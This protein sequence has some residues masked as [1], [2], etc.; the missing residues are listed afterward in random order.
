MPLRVYNSL[1]RRV[2][3]FVPADPPRV[4]LYACGPTVYDAVHVGNCSFYLAVDVL[5]RW[6]RHRGYE[7]TYVQNVTDVED[8]I[9]RD[10]AAAGED[11]ATFTK[12]WTDVY[13]RDL[14]RLDCLAAVDAFPRATEYVDRMV[15]MIQTLLDKGHAYLAEDGS[16]YFRVAS[17]PTYGEL[18]HLRPEDL[19][20]G[21]SGR[22]LADEYDK[23]S[24]GDFALWKAWT[25]EDGEVAWE[26]TFAVEGRARAVKGRPGWHIECS[27][28]ASALLGDQI[29]VHLGGEDLLFPHHQNEIAQSEAATG[30]RP[31]VRYWMHRRHLL[32]D[33][34]KM[35]KSKKNFYTLDDLIRMRGPGAPRAFRY[36]VVTAHYR[37][38]ID[39]TLAGL[40]AAAKTLQNLDE[41]RA[42]IERLAG[43]A[44]PSAWAGPHAEAFAKA[45]DDDLE[46][47]GAIAA[48]HA[49]VGEANR[50]IGAGAL[51]AADAASAR[52]LLATAYAVL[53]LERGRTLVVGEGAAD[54]LS[55]EVRRLVEARR[56]A[57]AGRDWAAADRLRDEL[58]A[59]GVRVK[60]TKDGQEIT[61]L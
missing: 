20:A 28:M 17:F 32:V 21:A 58:E 51:A 14:E 4:S 39:F 34:G 7:V 54:A 38:P 27:V 53:G 15:G 29:D 48:V 45:M 6:L 24:V 2:E 25:P 42:R 55:D 44:A 40:D 12:R 26:P 1:T 43:D 50:R 22:V 41:A 11:R 19:K 52:D 5:V 18:V 56:A 31:F 36:M 33:G 47:S 13:F 10:A 8:K 61:V 57:R 23:E 59:R 3:E 46:T 30:K 49:L 37:S 9:I 35:S 16:I 60:D